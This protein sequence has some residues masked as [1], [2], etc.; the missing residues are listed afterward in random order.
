M[1]SDPYPFA[2]MVSGAGTNLQALI[3][4]IHRDDAQPARCVLVIA[5]KAGA[6]A[7]ERAAAAGIPTQVVSLDDHDGDREA[8]DR[9]LAEA[10]AASGAELVVMAGWMS[11]VTGVLLGRFPDRV[12]NLHPSLLPSFAGM[13]AIEDAL[14][15]G[16]RVT[17]VTVHFAEE[18][19]DGGPPILQEAVPVLYGDTVESLRERI[20]VVEHRLLTEAVSLFARGRVRRD[21][22]RRR[23]VEI[24]MQGDQ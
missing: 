14:E 4:R 17:G 13:H 23:Q 3:D 15:W 22:A 12:I 24:V 7:L 9:A 1:V 18:Q 10:I 21:P 2:V 16:V 8:R 5:S 19:V 6:P 20:R 11:I